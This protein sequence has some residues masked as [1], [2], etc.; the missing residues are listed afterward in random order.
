MT[1]STEQAVINQLTGYKRLCGRIK[2]LHLQP[3]GMGMNI[4]HDGS[5][6]LLQAL[7]KSLKGKPSHMYLTPKQQKLEITAYAYLERYPFGT[8]SQLKEVKRHSGS[9]AEDKANLSELAR[10]IQKVIDTRGS[11]GNGN[12]DVYKRL[13]ELQSTLDEKRLIDNTLE[14]IGEYAPDLERLLKSRY[15]EGKSVEEVASD[16]GIVRKTFDRWKQKALEEYAI[17]IGMSQTCP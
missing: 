5:E 2:L 8:K 3:I 7:H 17:I 11:S 13:D 10:Q 14:T 1:E 4:D 12:A 15:I 16:L 6:D 9:D